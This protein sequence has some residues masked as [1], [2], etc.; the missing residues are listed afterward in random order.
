[1]NMPALTLTQPYASLIAIGA[2]HIE[3]RSW[4][5]N[6]RG[7]L[8]IHAAQGLGP[9][10]GEREL[11]RLC[12]REPFWMALRDIL[13]PP[14]RMLYA[15]DALPRG[16]I[17]AVAELYDCRPT[18][19]ARDGKLGWSGYLDNR[20]NYWDLTDQERA[21]GDYSPGRY[22]WLLANIRALP[23]PIPAKGAQGLWRWNVPEGV[24]V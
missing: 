2:K 19:E 8:A 7:P 1:M 17:V 11:Q 15:A 10:G 21:F 23:E 24:E 20:L 9:V 5:T 22:A 12:Q 18:I 14:G 16:A 3:T 4:Y 6:Y 13:M